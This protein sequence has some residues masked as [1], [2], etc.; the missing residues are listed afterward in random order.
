MMY[1]IYWRDGADFRNISEIKYCMAIDMGVVGL[2]RPDFFLD[3]RPRG[4]VNKDIQTQ[5]LGNQH[6]YYMGSPRLVKQWRKKDFVNTTFTV[7]MDEHVGDDGVHWP[8]M[9]D[10]PGEG[11]GPDQVLRMHDH[12]H[13]VEADH[14]MFFIEQDYI[15]AGGVC[16]NPFNQT[17]YVCSVC[18]HTYDPLVDGDGK[19]FEDLA[20]DWVCPVCGQ[21]KSKYKISGVAAEETGEA[22]APVPSALEVDVN[23]WREVEYTFSPV[24]KPPV[25][26][27][28]PAPAA[29]QYECSVCSH[30][31]DPEQDGSGKAFEDLP[32]D[33]VCPV[34]AQ[35]KSSYH[36]KVVSVMI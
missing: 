12:K 18:L 1:L 20:E 24:W 13:L 4:A 2:L 14:K 3:S 23:A 6:T 32:E 11:S 16:H 34:C 9:M 26:T 22:P 5:Y 35:P 10:I 21:P 31:Y 33:W 17:K 27:P 36:E 7:S 29:A 15:A 30:V 8:L 19:S 25:P 28:T